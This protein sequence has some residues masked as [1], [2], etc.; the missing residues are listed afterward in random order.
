MRFAG[1]VVVI[2]G[3]AGVIG[4]A[5]SARFAAEG[6]KVVAVDL[7]GDAL[8]AATSALRESGA[9]VV[10]VAA[11]VTQT[12]EVR[13]YF[14]AAVET[15]GGVDFFLN[16]AGIEGAVAPLVDYPDDAFDRVMLVNVKG[17][18]LG[19]KAAAPLLRAR[20]G[21]SI[22]N[23]ASIAGLLAT[24]NFAAYGASKHAVVGLTRT[25]ATEFAQSNIRVNA[26]CPTFIESRMVSALES[27]L[28]PAQPDAVRTL[29]Q[30]RIPMRRYGRPEEVAALMAFLCS[31]DASYITG[32]AYPLDGGRTAG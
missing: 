12:E 8:D 18:W 29:I 23:T 4:R 6:A 21:G 2:T 26:V 32:A 20:G 7:P 31:E 9:E 14:A 25:A 13:G 10:S 19:L 22:V 15:F 1:K 28:N 30:S 17:V 5:A 16:N 27:G 11:D 24:P 3:A